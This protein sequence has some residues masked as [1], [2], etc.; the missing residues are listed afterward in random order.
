MDIH[1]EPITQKRFHLAV[2]SY[3]A[4]KRGLLHQLRRQYNFRELKQT[5]SRKTLLPE[6]AQDRRPQGGR[7]LCIH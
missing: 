3:Q 4:E 2:K 1:S 6:S 7:R 5:P